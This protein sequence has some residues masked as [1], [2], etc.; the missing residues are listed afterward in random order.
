[1]AI[2]FKTVTLDAKIPMLAISNIGSASEQICRTQLE[3][4]DHFNKAKIDMLE[5][6][7]K[8]KDQLF[9]E[10]LNST[11]TSSHTG[12]HASQNKNL[13]AELKKRYLK[14]KQ[15]YEEAEAE[16]KRLTKTVKVVEIQVDDDVAPLKEKI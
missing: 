10:S 8:A 1:M 16:I 6:K 14:L 5:K 2:P 13:V 4:N 12:M 11:I 3:M 7:V 9:E 15:Q